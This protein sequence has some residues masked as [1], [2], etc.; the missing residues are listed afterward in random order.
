MRSQEGRRRRQGGSR[1]LVAS[2]GGVVGL[3]EEGCPVRRLDASTS[4]ATHRRQ[5][6]RVS[7]TVLAAWWPDGEGEE[8]KGK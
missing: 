3:G 5:G 1:A 2:R 7:G 4:A 8:K 6:T